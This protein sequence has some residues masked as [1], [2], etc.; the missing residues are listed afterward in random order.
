MMSSAG[1]PASS[2]AL[3]DHGRVGHVQLPLPHAGEDFVDIALE[4]I[5]RLR[6]YRAA[7]DVQGVDRELRVHPEFANAVLA[8]ETRG[9]DGV[10]FRLVA[11]SRERLH[12]RAV[13]WST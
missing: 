9:L 10:V 8:D 6:E 5:L 13:Y 2:R 4:V 1:S 11:Y 3:G 7:H 12:G